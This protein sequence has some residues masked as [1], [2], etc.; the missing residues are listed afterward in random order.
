MTTANGAKP[1]KDS[2]PRI[3]VY[4][5]RCGLNIAKT[6]DCEKVAETAKQIPD[7]VVSL[8]MP[9]QNRGR[10][11]FGKIFGNTDWI[12]LW[13]RHARRGCMSRLSAR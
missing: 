4:V 3:G 13:W 1:S 2:N 5:C 12:G 9:V 8:L 11:K 10:R 6:V 7:V